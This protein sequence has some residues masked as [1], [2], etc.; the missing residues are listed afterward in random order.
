MRTVFW[1][2]FEILYLIA[3]IPEMLKCKRLLRRGETLRVREIAQKRVQ[4]WAR[5]ML[6][7]AGVTVEV[8]GLENMDGRPCIIVGNHQSDWDIPVVLGY[9]DKSHGIVAKDS[10]AKIPLIKTWMDLVGCIFIDRS[11]PRKALRTISDAGKRVTEGESIIIFPEGTRSKGEEIGEFKAGAFKTAFKYDAPI[12]PFAIDGPY[13]IMEANGGKWIRPG[14]VVLTILPPVE[15]A[16]MERAEQKE[17]GEKVREMILAAR[18]DSRKQARS[19]KSETES[20]NDT[21]KAMQ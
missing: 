1:L 11:D 20:E 9:L 12:Q 7:A 18:E 3:V 10:I 4:L 14:H 15:T 8:H 2:L 17:F 16:G 5:S 6:K 13:K 21:A 19:A